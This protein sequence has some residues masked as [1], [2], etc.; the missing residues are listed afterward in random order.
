MRYLGNKE[1]L[2]TAI[3]DLLQEKDLLQKDLIF[4]DAFCGMGSVADSVKSIYDHLI[5]NDSL[6]CATVFTRGRLYANE[7]NFVRLGFNPFEYLNENNIVNKGFFYRNYSLGRSERMYFSEYNAARIDY[8]RAQIEEWKENDLLTEKEYI[9]L[10]ACLLE[11]VSDV[12]NTAGVYGAFLKHWDKRALKP[13]TF[14]K[15]DAFVG[16]PKTIVSFNDKIENIITDVYCDIIYL[17]PPYTQNQYGTQ[18]HLLETLILNDNPSISKITGSRPTAP[19]RSDWSKMYHAHILFEKIIAETTASHIIL[20]YNNDG[21]MTKDFIEKTLKRFGLEETYACTTIDYKKYNNTKC[22][23]ANGHQEYLFYIQKKPVDSV[24]VQSPLNYTGSKTKMIDI[25]KQNLP[26]HH[27]ETF[28]DVFGGGFNVG[29][30]ISAERIIYNDINPFVVQLIESFKIDTYSYLNYVAKLI[31]QYNL[32]PNNKEGYYA[33]REK[34]NKTP[35]HERDPRMLYTLILYGFQQQIRFNAE[36]GFNNPVGSRW[37]NECLLS[38]FITFARYSKKKNVEYSNVSFDEFADRITSETFIYADPP[39][40]STLGVYNDGK[41]G[42]EG[43]TKEHELRLC[44]FLDLANQVGAKFMLS[45][46]LQVDEF[47]NYEMANWVEI[48]HYHIIDIEIPQGR[49]NKRREVLI[50]NY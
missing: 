31:R 19:M 7:C 3:I 46:V 27:F 2:T 25:I 48:N 36:F 45:Y 14:N 28:I 22:Q 13:I 6:K 40:R 32:S 15:I 41:R 29:I 17:D 4:F 35:I 10:L 18:Y 24:I 38:K 43:W 30:N 50:K 26:L 5:V 1:S 20:S 8:F 23:G 12:S 49:Y 16:V 33:L 11:S 9:Y 47:Y 34:Y 21:L 42:F 44:T 37:F 39:Y